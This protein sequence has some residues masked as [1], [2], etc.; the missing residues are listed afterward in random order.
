MSRGTSRAETESGDLGPECRGAL[1][2][3]E[4]RPPEFED[5]LSEFGDVLSEIRY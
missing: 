5:V 4:R 3:W 1:S 2:P